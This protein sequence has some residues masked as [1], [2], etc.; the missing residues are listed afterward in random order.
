[1][2][3]QVPVIGILMIV[4]GSCASL[5]GL[6]LA[7][8][9]P[10]FITLMRQ[11]APPPADADVV[12]TITFLFY[13]IVGVVVLGAG[14]MNIV[15]GVRALYY[16]NRGLVIT[17]LFLNILPIFTCY[18]APTSLG[19]MIYGLIVMF[20]SEVAQ[21]FA[22]GATGLSAEQIRAEMSYRQQRQYDPDWNDYDEDRPADDS[23]RRPPPPE[24]RPSAGPED[25]QFYSRE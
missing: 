3:K 17:A 24:P 14:I 13:L 22:L 6:L 20:N 9:G 4:N 25:E 7:V 18:C 12:L 10:A 1:M 11:E 23:P 5:L 15:G 16:R 19:M 21:A 2:T 8:G